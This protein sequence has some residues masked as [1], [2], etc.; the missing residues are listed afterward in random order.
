[1]QMTISD[2]FDIPE[3]EGQPAP[4]SDEE[5]VSDE[6]EWATLSTGEKNR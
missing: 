5:T 3:D 6:L 4:E 1:M 2:R